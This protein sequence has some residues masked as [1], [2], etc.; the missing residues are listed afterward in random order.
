MDKQEYT[1]K[2]IKIDVPFLGYQ[3]AL[4]V[5][6]EKAITSCG[7][8]SVAMILKYKEKD[9]S[10][11]D[12]INTGHEEKGYGPHGWVHEYFVQLLGKYS[13]PA[14]RKEN[15]PRQS[16]GSVITQSILAQKPVI[17][18]GRKIFMEQTSFHM[19]LVV[20]IRLDEQD[21]CIGFFYHDPALTIARDAAYRFVSIDNFHQ[22]WRQMAIV[23]E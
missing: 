3:E 20:G 11:T 15:M 4:E 22:Y 19:V 21:N 5:G 12:L 2:D 16:I 9:I 14:T 10:L 8:C 6:Y 1:Y 18:S 7:M 23:L 17:I 13:L